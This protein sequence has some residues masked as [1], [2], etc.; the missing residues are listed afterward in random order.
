MPSCECRG[1]H[2][3]A[4]AALVLISY[5]LLLRTLTRTANTV[6]HAAAAMSTISTA[7]DAVSPVLTA[8][9][10]GLPVG[11]PL[12]ELPDAFFVVTVTEAG[13]EVLPAL[14]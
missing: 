9:T 7:K 3:R 13:T 8:T 6:A 14:S 10:P 12:S 11:A 2:A 4:A 1:R 5:R